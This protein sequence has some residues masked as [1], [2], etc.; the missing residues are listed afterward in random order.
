ML[1]KN[2]ICLR[3]L[4]IL[5]LVTA[6]GHLSGCAMLY[7]A[8]ISDIDNRET[9]ALVPFE[10]KVSETGVDLQQAGAIARN[11]LQNS[12]SAQAADGA[13]AIVGLFQMG[14]RTGKPVYADSYAQKLVY[15]IHQQCPSGRITGVTS[16]RESRDYP[17]IS[18]EIVKIKGYC[19]RPRRPATDRTIENFEN[20]DEE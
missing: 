18:G 10:I 11:V 13:A 6:A 3:G 2:R 7:K 19:M 9:F 5:I 4:M 14:P 17:V 16:I 12:E 8:Q 1:I 15:A 20:E